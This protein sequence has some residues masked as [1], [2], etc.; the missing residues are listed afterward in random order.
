MGWTEHI[1]TEPN[2]TRSSI[3]FCAQYLNMQM[4]SCKAYSLAVSA[5]ETHR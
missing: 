5:K 4:G 3:M 2:Q 1:T